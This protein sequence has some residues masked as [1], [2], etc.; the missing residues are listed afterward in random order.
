MPNLKKYEA[1]LRTQKSKDKLDKIRAYYLDGRELPEKAKPTVALYEE[2]NGLLCS[3]YSTNQAVQFLMKKHGIG[4]QYAYR[5]LAESAQLFG[6]VTQHTK[7]G[8]RHIQAERYALI[9]NIARQKGDLAAALEA[10]S[11]IDKLYGLHQ[12]EG[13]GIDMRQIIM[14]TVINFTTD[15]KALVVQETQIDNEG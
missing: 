9:A 5:I 7:D 13:D 10:L 3:G 14:P 4:R 1:S 11:K 8:R 12:H 6:D 2:A 15:I